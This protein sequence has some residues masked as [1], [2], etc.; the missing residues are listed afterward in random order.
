[1]VMFGSMAELST[2]WKMADIS[3]ALMA[4]TNLTAILLLSDVAFKLAKDYNHQRSLG[5]L[6]TFDINHYPELGSQL[7]PGIWKPSRQR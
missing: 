4:I 5:K 6:P 3:M 1:M 2:V 7:E